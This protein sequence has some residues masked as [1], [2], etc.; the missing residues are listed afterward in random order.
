MESLSGRELMLKEKFEGR[1]GLTPKGVDEI[2]LLC[3]LRA[4]L[5]VFTFL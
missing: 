5:G 2:F 1:E 3:I 4:I